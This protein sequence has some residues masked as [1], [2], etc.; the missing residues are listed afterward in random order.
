MNLASKSDEDDS[1]CRKDIIF[2]MI[3]AR[4][5][6]NLARSHV[7]TGGQGPPLLFGEFISLVSQPAKAFKIERRVYGVLIVSLATYV[8]SCSNT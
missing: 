1:G 4:R 2:N 3:D 6:A 8:D 5:F 7:A